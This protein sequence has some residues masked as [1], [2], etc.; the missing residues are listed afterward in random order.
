ME[1]ESRAIGDIARTAD[2]R[3]GIA[4]FVGKRAPRFRGE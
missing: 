3:E 4:A 1:L 2:A